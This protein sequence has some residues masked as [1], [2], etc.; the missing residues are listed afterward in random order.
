[1]VQLPPDDWELRDI[2]AAELGDEPAR[3]RVL[4][5]LAEAVKNNTLDE[6]QRLW[7]EYMLLRIAQQTDPIPQKGGRHAARYLTRNL[8]IVDEVDGLI[9]EQSLQVAAACRALAKRVNVAIHDGDL[10]MAKLFHAKRRDKNSAYISGKTL[11][12]AYHQ[13]SDAVWISRHPD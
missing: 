10:E 2:H 6:R 13:T 11:E 7:L 1:M 8:W 4:T 3:M 12:N 5:R 9:S